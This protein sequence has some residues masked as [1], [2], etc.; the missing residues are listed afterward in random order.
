MQQ[1][2]IPIS[3]IQ[4]AQRVMEDSPTCNTTEVP[5]VEAM[6]LL[7]PQIKTMQAKGYGLAHIAKLLSQTGISVTEV[8]LKNY[9]NRLKAS[10]EKASSRRRKQPGTLD[11]AILDA[12]QQRSG[13]KPNLSSDPAGP[14]ASPCRESAG[15]RGALPPATSPAAAS[16][17]AESPRRGLPPSPQES[18]AR[19][20]G[21]TVR[22]DTK[23]I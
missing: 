6:R 10:T 14:S 18:G 4:E 22:P 23:D 15:S 2:K 17:L 13:T 20:A 3:A 11:P 5:K 12:A 8:T 19:R 9:V 16:G 21:F 7:L 1:H